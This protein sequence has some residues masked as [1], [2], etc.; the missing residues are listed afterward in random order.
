MR[1][2]FFGDK[3]ATEKERFPE[4]RVELAFLELFYHTRPD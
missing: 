1:C 4:L 2:S 3:N